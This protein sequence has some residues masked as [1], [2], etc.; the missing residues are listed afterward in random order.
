LLQNRTAPS[1]GLRFEISD[2]YDLARLTDEEFDIS[3]FKGISTTF[4]IRSTP[5]SSS[6]TEHGR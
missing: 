6:P 4:L 5:R 3:L 2:V 1:D